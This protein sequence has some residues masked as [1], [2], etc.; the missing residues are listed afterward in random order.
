[1]NYKNDALLLICVNFVNNVWI[2]GEYL[3]YGVFKKALDKG[4][5]ELLAETAENVEQKAHISALLGRN[6]RKIY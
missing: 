3:Y 4:S 2:K 6:I 1:M 5:L